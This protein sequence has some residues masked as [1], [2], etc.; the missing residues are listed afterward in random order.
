MTPPIV[1]FCKSYRDDVLRARQLA[2]SIVKFNADALPFYMAV[3]KAD[4]G[5]FRERLAGLPVELLTDEQIVAADPRI[6]KLKFA[7]ARGYVGQQVVKASFWR[8]GKAENYLW[9][10][11]DS[12]FIKEFRTGD[13][14]GAGG[15]PFTVMHEAK[16]LLQFGALKNM[17]KVARDWE[18]T[19]AKVMDRFG[20][21][22]RIWAFGPSPVIWS[23]K[24]LRDLDEKLLLP[25]GLTILDALTELPVELVWYG[26]ALLAF[27]SIPIVPI[28]PLF[29]VYHYEEQ[30][31]FWKEA[32]E[33]D[34]VVAA[35]YFG[36]CRQSAWDKDLDPVKK[37]KF[38][39]LRRKILRALGL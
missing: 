13:F 11:S 20:S 34:A 32:G 7:A 25:R 21:R 15:V 18:N 30:Y 4:I 17:R 8:L 12:Y 10:D 3:P 28:E 24:V 27:K 26:E 35:N 29:R 14:I 6:D 1:L 5:L 2:E 9:L 33:T 23:N 31:Y 39:K 36:V 38:S 19:C 22:H 16:E 37:F